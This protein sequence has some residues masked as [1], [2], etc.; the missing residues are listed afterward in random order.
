MNGDAE[1]DKR[2]RD[3]L[4]ANADP[5][6]AN[7]VR[8]AARKWKVNDREHCHKLHRRRAAKFNGE[9]AIDALYLKKGD[10]LENAFEAALSFAAIEFEKLDTKDRQAYPDYLVKVEKQPPLIVE[11]KSKASPEDLVPLNAAMDVLGASELTGYKDH[12][13]I[14]LCSPGVEPSVPSL[15]EACGRLCV[16]EIADLVEALLRLREGSLTRDELYNW[17]TTPGIAL[18][19]DLPHPN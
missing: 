14:T 12:F 11:L 7:Q 4:S 13:C 3:A 19:E 17:L 10:A 6:V 5:A 9:E 2:R 8:D 18:M 1:T 15:I 16:I